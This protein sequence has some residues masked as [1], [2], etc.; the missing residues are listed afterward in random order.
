MA[1]L[2][3]K[4][5]KSMFLVLNQYLVK[6]RKPRLARDATKVDIKRAVEKLFRLPGHAG[7]VG[8]IEGHSRT[9][10]GGCRRLRLDARGRIEG[11]F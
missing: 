8:I 7:R 5:R 6:G 3:S 9:F 11:L 2:L 10:C 1:R 4:Q